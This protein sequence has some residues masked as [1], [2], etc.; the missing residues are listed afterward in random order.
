[1]RTNILIVLFLATTSSAIAQLKITF[2]S[3]D[4]VAITADWYP[5]NSESQT[6]L[7]CHQNG[8][9]RGEYIETAVKLN[10]LGFNCLAIDQR[11]GVEVNGVVNETAKDA[12][13]KKK[14]L[15]F[16]NAEQDI[17]AAVEWLYSK[18]KRRIILLG[19]SYSASLALKV[20]NEND[21]VFAAVA[22]SPGEYFDGENF[23]ATHVNGLKKPV[24]LTSSKEEAPGV[25][26]L[27]KDIISLVKVQFIPKGEGDHGSKVL[28]SSKPENQD[29]WA[30]L[31]SFLNRMKKENE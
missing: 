17:T 1:M 30:A 21:H 20:A 3:K 9:S 27:S 8:F 24:F 5:V 22:F 2:P 16:I 4:D 11:V 31:M 19:S 29:Y 28:W 18:Y 14:V 23:I 7:L 25:T 26:E 15:T 6:I 12:K 10:K 13:D